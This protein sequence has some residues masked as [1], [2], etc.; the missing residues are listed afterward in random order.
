MFVHKPSAETRELLAHQPIEERTTIHE[1]RRRAFGLAPDALLV[2]LSAAALVL[3]V[4]LFAVGA[5]LGG[6]IVLALG[7]ASIGLFACAVRDDPTSRIARSTRR[8][9]TRAAGSARF[10]VTAGRTW[11]SA[12]V[13][14]APIVRR[15]RRLRRQFQGQLAPLGEAFYQED[16]LR[17][18]RLR[19]QAAELEHAIREADEQAAA[20]METARNE[21][22]QEKATVQATQTLPPLRPRSPAQPPR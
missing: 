7:C 15:R 20:V 5:W 6:A 12:A 10:A 3:A 21:V 2:G 4:I 14:L 16:K 13:S 9:V 11:S 19:S 18:E 8:V 1:A 22:K 17:A